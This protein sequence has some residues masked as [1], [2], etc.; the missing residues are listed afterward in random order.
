MSLEYN[1][2]DLKKNETLEID[3]HSKID[4]HSVNLSEKLDNKIKFILKGTLSCKTEDKQTSYTLLANLILVDIVAV[5]DKCLEEYDFDMSIQFEETIQK[6]VEDVDN[7]EQFDY[8]EFTTDGNILNLEPIINMVLT[9][10]F[11][12]K[13]VCSEECLGLCSICGNNLNIKQCNC[14]E[15]ENQKNSPFSDLLG[16]FN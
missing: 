11:P 3:F 10:N 5:C 7:A 8:E 15:E 2:A 12:N 13:L 6:V 9:M 1:I 16:K 4:F 14:I